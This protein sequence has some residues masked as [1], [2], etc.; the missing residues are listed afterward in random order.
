MKQLFSP[1]AD[2]SSGPW[3][4]GYRHENCH[5]CDVYW[6]S[7][8]QVQIS[9]LLLTQLFHFFLLTR[10][11]LKSVSRFVNPY[12]FRFRWLDVNKW[13]RWWWHDRSHHCKQGQSICNAFFDWWMLATEVWCSGTNCN[14]FFLT[15]YYNSYKMNTQPV[16]FCIFFHV[17]FFFFN[18]YE[19]KLWIVTKY[20]A[21]TS[22]SSIFMTHF[23]SARRMRADIFDKGLWRK[24]RI[25]K[26][27]KVFSFMLNYS[28]AFYM[29]EKSVKFKV[30]S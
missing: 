26:K 30:A 14:A 15:Q 29:I 4:R 24:H 16:Y 19:N 5:M 8:N 2:S 20:A 11:V 10:A 1:A 17:L 22:Q 9:Q 7:W 21:G 13:R 6:W 28:I 25:W 12:T 3:M 23:L 18:L 27:I